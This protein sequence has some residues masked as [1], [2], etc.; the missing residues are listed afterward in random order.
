MW[1]VSAVEVLYLFSQPGM[2]QKKSPHRRS[3][4][5]SSVW[6]WSATRAC[7]DISA[8]RCTFLSTPACTASSVPSNK[9]D[10]MKTGV[11]CADTEA[12][13]L[14]TPGCMVYF[15]GNANAWGGRSCGSSDKTC[16]NIMLQ[17]NCGALGRWASQATKL[18]WA[19][20]VQHEV[21]GIF[22]QGNVWVESLS[23]FSSSRSL[24]VSFSM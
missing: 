12:T 15:N 20:L 1:H 17:S 9:S 7:H 4:G 2:G 6:G 19:V 18:E 21:R 14:A 8:M 10:Y 13:A 16:Q 5:T 22:D 3:L 24:V 23:N 11:Q